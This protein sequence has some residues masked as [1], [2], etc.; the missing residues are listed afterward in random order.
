MDTTRA[1]DAFVGALI[2]RWLLDGATPA[3]AGRFAA[4]AAAINCQ[5]RFAQRGLPTR[6]QI[7]EFLQKRRG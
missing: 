1:G 4:A 6:E 5:E 7:D 3:D 2:D